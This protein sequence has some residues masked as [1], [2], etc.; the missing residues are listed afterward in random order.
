MAKPRSDSAAFRAVLGLFSL[1][2]E[3][4]RVVIFQRLTR[5][6]STAGDLARELPVS[7]T[8]IVQHL[9][10]MEATNLVTAESHGRKMVYRA[11]PSGLLPLL[12]WL[13]RHGA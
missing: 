5:N 2:G 1:F 12:N 11:V 8:A 9:K 7:R 6:P 10:R 4:I 3:P 13:K